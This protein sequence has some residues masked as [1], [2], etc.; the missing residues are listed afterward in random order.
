MCCAVEGLKV[1]VHEVLRTTAAYYWNMQICYPAPRVVVFDRGGRTTVRSQYVSL[2]AVARS[3]SRD[4][5]ILQDTNSALLLHYLAIG[6]EEVSV[7][8]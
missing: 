1:A 6:R 7:I 8:D 5:G 2:S 4:H 3:Q